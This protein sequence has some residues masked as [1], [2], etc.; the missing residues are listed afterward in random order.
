MSENKS[1][2]PTVISESVE[3]KEYNEL[4]LWIMDVL[5]W[6]DVSF[7]GSI[8]FIIV[9]FCYLVIIGGYSVLTLLSLCITFILICSFVYVNLLHIYTQSRW[10][11]PNNFQLKIYHDISILYNII[12]FM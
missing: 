2:T 5:L 1:G 10:D 3:N 4:S 7:T 9:L 6:D 11:M 8:A 12:M